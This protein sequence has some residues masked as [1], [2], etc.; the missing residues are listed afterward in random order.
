M[1]TRKTQQRQTLKG[2]GHGWHESLKGLR[3]SRAELF[4]TFVR[5]PET[6]VGEGDQAG[7]SKYPKTTDLEGKRDSSLAYIKTGTAYF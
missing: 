3:G 5:K 7:L 6:R 4:W 1:S 2:R